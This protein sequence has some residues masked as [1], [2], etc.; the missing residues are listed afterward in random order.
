MIMKTGKWPKITLVMILLSLCCGF[1]AASQ[2][3][4]AYLLPEETLKL[5]SRSSTKPIDELIT[6]AYPQEELIEYL[7]LERPNFCACSFHLE[8]A[9]PPECVRT[10][11]DSA[12]Y[13]VYKLQEGGLVF[14]FLDEIDLYVDYVFVVKKCLTRDDFRWIQEGSTLADVESV[15]PGAKLTLSI[16]PDYLYIGGND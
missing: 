7:G 9:Y 3:T 2:N 12:T 16:H 5:L 13:C 15:D 1:T 8:E 10:F 11:A 4:S 14:V 6:T